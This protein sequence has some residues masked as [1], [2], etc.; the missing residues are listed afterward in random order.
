MINILDQSTINKIAAGE[1]IERPMSIVKELVENSVDAEASQITVEIKDGGLSYI[2]VT[3]N[4]NGIE[5]DDV[6]KAYMRHATSKLKTAEELM[7]IMTLGFRG[8]AL[9]TIAAVTE[10]E[11]VT[12]RRDSLTGIKYVINGGQEKELAEVGAPDGTTV[13]SRNIFFNTPA[14]L[15][16]LKTATTEGSYINDLMIRVALSHPSISIKLINN[17]KMIINTSGNGKLR[18][19]VYAVYGRDI[20][21]NLLPV[22]F[23]EDGIG[24]SGFIGKPFISKGNRSFETYFINGRYITN[25]VITKAIEEAFRTYIMQHKFPFTVLYLDLDPKMCDVNIH[26]TKKEFKYYNEKALFHAVYHAVADALSNREIISPM[27]LTEEKEERKSDNINSSIGIKNQINNSSNNINVIN[28]QNSNIVDGISITDYQDKN[29]G[30]NVNNTGSNNT[31][32]NNTNRTDSNNDFDKTN[33]IHSN[34]NNGTKSGASHKDVKFGINKSSYK[35]LEK[36][37]PKEYLAEVNEKKPYGDTAREEEQNEPQNEKQDVYKET[38][39]EIH[40]ETSKEKEMIGTQKNLFED[41]Y[42]SKEAI[43]HHRIIGLAF[44]T[45]WISQYKDALYLMDQHAAHEKVNY[46][47]FLKAFKERSIVSQR[48]FPPEIISLS[49][50]EMN[51]VMDNLEYF[52]NCGFEIDEFGGNEVKI[53]SMPVNYIDFS[54]RDVFL[55][56]VSYLVQNISGI[57]EDLFVTRLATMGCKAAV[58]GNQRISVNEAQKLIE[59]LLTLDNPYTC[60]HGRPTIIKLTKEEL[61]KKF[62]RIV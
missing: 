55:Q 52:R 25:A 9:S 14:R 33:S 26:P 19:T 31:G 54:G 28:S 32:N 48:V 13:I 12:K 50:L 46:E 44:D 10:T 5:K 24:I 38:Y 39:K 7:G 41:D 8:E 22:D 45:Y 21:S 40:E 11:M 34:I 53:S 30:N 20:T 37:L 3:D 36:L 62:K 60:P 47:R 35:I 27:K 18:D 51:A 6:R 43:S 42:I 61:E 15:K 56:F 59:D 1:V 23:N 17:G 58:K 29:S 2:R 49:S 57:T 4:G 16:F